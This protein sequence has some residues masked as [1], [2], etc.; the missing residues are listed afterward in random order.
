MRTPPSAGKSPWGKV[1]FEEAVP[2]LLW[3][4]IFSQPNISIQ[5]FA[6]VIAK[7]FYWLDEFWANHC[8][9]LV[10]LTF[11]YILKNFSDILMKLFSRKQQKPVWRNLTRYESFNRKNLYSFILKEN[12]IK[13]WLCKILTMINSIE[14]R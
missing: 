8:S 14:N 11:T 4:R 9:I 7:V 12:N 13:S 5:N 3:L 6:L 10:Y 2:K 1:I